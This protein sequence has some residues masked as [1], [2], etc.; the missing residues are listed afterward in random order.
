M[1]SW[2]V[3]SKETLKTIIDQVKAENPKLK[4]RV[5]FVGYRDFGDGADQYSTIDFQEDVSSV[6]AFIAKQNATGGSD[7]PED[8]QGGFHKALGMSW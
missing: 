3:R 1:C 6:K 5:A 4:V 2:I 8:V 7:H